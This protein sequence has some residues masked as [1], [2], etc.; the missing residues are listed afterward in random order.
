MIDFDIELII[1]F[2]MVFKFDVLFIIKFVLILC[3]SFLGMIDLGELNFR[4]VFIFLILVL[5]VIFL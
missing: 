3:V 4:C 2:F 1:N 5:V